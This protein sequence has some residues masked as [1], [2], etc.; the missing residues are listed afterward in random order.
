MRLKTKE[1]PLFACPLWQSA[2]GTEEGWPSQRNLKFMSNQKTAVT[3]E[4]NNTHWWH[5]LSSVPYQLVA[6]TQ[7]PRDAFLQLLTGHKRSR[8]DLGQW[9]TEAGPQQ[10]FFPVSVPVLHTASPSAPTSRAGNA[11]QCSSHGKSSLCL[12]LLPLVP[13]TQPL[14]SARRKLIF[15][16]ILSLLSSLLSGAETQAMHCRLHTQQCNLVPPPCKLKVV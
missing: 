9:E 5:E 4:V 14:E 15:P 2:C 16:N 13:Q 12:A 8:W 6:S 1:P 10:S 11:V 3:T 7:L